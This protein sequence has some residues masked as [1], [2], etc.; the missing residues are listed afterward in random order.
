[1]DLTGALARH[2][3][4]L[5][6]EDLPESAIEMAK[7]CFLDLMGVAIR[8]S[9]E[10]DSS[11]PLREAVKELS[12]GGGP[13]TAVGHPETYLPHYAALLNGT[14]AH[15][16]DFDDTHRA[17]SLHPGAPVIPAALALA[18]ETG[19]GGPDL[20]AA[21][22]AGY[23]VACR[24]G[25]ALNPKA[26]YDKGFHPT[27]TAGLFG[28]TAAGARV[29]GLGE[30]LLDNAFG[31]NGSQAAGSL[32][33]LESGAWNK[34]LHPGLAAHNAILSLRLAAKGV[35]GARRALEGTYGLLCA[36]SPSPLPEKITEGLGED[37]EILNTALKP[38]PSCRFTHAALDCIIDI[39]KG[40]KVG[41]GELESITI[42]L[43]RKGIDWVGHPPERKRRPENVV[44]G[45]FSMHF[46][47]AVA[48]SK[49]AFGWEDYRMLREHS[50]LSLMDRIEVAEDP[51]VEKHYPEHMGARVKI[52][53]RGKEFQRE[54]LIPKGEPESPLSWEEIEE[55]FHELSRVGLDERKRRAFIKK[56]KRLEKEGDVREL[57]SLLRA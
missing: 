20:I 43:P 36:Y 39:V 37:F 46:V 42:G 33:F 54:S 23:D 4:R 22:V 53:A 8:A 16:L 6:Y 1:M 13:S 47:G 25:K 5:S 56:V 24:V 51:E 19:A 35:L 48:A 3:V 44:D 28:A 52:R 40:E 31:L 38:Y 10:A 26:H 30:E 17:G 49:G 14:Y 2:A 57:V 18:E 11:A 45:Q 12:P 29:M 34:R 15:S 7:Q 55:K 27:A 21:I 50:L 41:A 32:Q 9:F